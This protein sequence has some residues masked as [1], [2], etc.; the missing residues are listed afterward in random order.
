MKKYKYEIIQRLS[1]YSQCSLFEATIKNQ[2]VVE[3]LQFDIDKCEYLGTI[4]ASLNISERK[5]VAFA[6]DYLLSKVLNNINENKSSQRPLVLFNQI[7]L[8]H[9]LMDYSFQQNFIYLNFLLRSVFLSLQKQIKEG[10]LFDP[11]FKFH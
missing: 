11:Q 5:E 2:T 6:I 1:S 9:A 10:L 8:V 4:F 7:F 3:V